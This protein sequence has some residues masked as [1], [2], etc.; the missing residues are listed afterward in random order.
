[1]FLHQTKQPLECG[2]GIE[3]EKQVNACTFSEAMKVTFTQR[4][5]ALVV[6]TLFSASHDETVRVWDVKFLCIN[7]ILR[8][9]DLKERTEFLQDQDNAQKC[10]VKKLSIKFDGLSKKPKVNIAKLLL[11]EN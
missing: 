6:T 11:C 9:E 8:K 10:G 7:F 1:L 2:S 4:P 5:L 3:K